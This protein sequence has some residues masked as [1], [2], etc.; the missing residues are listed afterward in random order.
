M[1]R[2]F[3]RP[4]QA[5]LGAWLLVSGVSA[6]DVPGAGARHGIAMHGEPA[7]PAGFDHLPYVNPNAPKSG[8]IT[9]ALQGTFDSI[10][11]LIVLGV[12]PDVVP[13]YVLQSLL[14]RSQDEPFTLYGLVAQT[15]EMP[16]DRSYVA[17][18]LDPRAR[19]S[20]GT[21]LTSEDV[22][23][24]FELLKT[25]GKPLQRS[26]F[27]LVKAVTVEGAHRIRFDLTGA[28]DRELPLIIGLMPVLPA[29]ATDPATFDRTTFTPPIGSGPYRIKEIRPGERIV[30][31]RRPDFWGA[32]LPVL[33]GLYNFA[34]I[35]YD[36]YRDANTLFEAF[37][38]GL[39][40]F[41]AE[42]EPGRW[43][44]GYDFPAVRQ[45]RIKLESFTNRLPKGMNGFV[46]NTRKE[47]FQDPRVRQALG[48]MFDF[49]WINRNL[50]FG[51]LDRSTSYFAASD[52]SAYEKSPTDRER[53][54]L[55]PYSRDLVPTILEGR[56]ALP[57]GDGSGRDRQ[58]AHKAL[59]LLK[60]A[61]W[62]IGRGALRRK[63]TGEA[64][65]FEML[66]NSRQ[67]ERLA[68]N[69]A[70]TLSRIGVRARVRL[71]DDVQYWR[72]L[73]RFDY[74]MIQWVWP[75]SASPGNEQR[76]RWGAANVGRDG[77]FNYA[78]VASPAAD[79]MI[80]ALLGATSREDF[81]AS[82]RALDRVLMSGFY[83]VPLFYIPAQWVAYS[84]DLRRP[85]ALPLFGPNI[86]FWWREP[87]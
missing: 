21:P 30:L 48:Y 5:I 76:N 85:E 36:F 80:D 25:S 74:D 87:R 58:S 82:V 78:G 20:D 44:T 66:V 6:Q 54:L 4:L 39:Y 52:L 67:Q 86:D 63:G 83:V 24:T 49:D 41:R 26:L 70:S 79:R 32:D 68:L 47:I 53:E 81:V 2:L 11:P 60:E 7:L 12:A 1:W 73:S 61:G 77:S 16:E 51:L 13:R 40:D 84:A 64:F 56:W 57:D 19:F 69:F 23:F 17:F 33:K 37:K 55:E 62:E 29:H 46:F 38:A 27:G 72:R 18:N 45:G 50:Y 34:E 31:E 15:V 10:N 9:L 22:R 42:G 14:M 3:R 65:S 75:A 28:N 71:V 8:R 35:R 59:D 43:S